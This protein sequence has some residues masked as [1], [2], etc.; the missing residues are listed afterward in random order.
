MGDIET[1]TT[2]TAAEEARGWKKTRK[3][4]FYSRNIGHAEIHA[5]EMDMQE[6]SFSAI[7]V[8]GSFD[9]LSEAIAAAEEASG[10]AALDEANTARRELDEAR[11]DTAAINRRL[12]FALV[13]RDEARAEV[14]TLRRR[15]G[16]LET[17][18]EWAAYDPE[19]FG[20]ELFSSRA[21]AIESVNEAIEICREDASEGWPEDVEQ[22]RLLRVAGAAARSIGYDSRVDYSF[23]ENGTETL[24]ALLAEAR[25]VAKGT[26][27]LAVGLKCADHGLTFSAARSAV[28]HVDALVDVVRG[29]GRWSGALAVY[30]EACPGWAQ[31]GTVEG[32]AANA[33][34]FRENAVA[35]AREQG[36]REVVE[37]LPTA[38]CV[39]A[40]G[41]I[42][43]QTSRRLVS[44]MTLPTADA[45][46]D[47][48]G[49]GS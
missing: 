19:G 39:A 25:D 8:P 41:F 34:R 17:G 6:G 47:E 29:K 10:V 20:F 44:E 30:A 18:S 13:S 11:A 24:N 31:D 46:A 3:T 36:R 45:P 12:E 15:V 28:E 26:E 16:E 48:D 22:I 23:R 21:K 38:A 35:E 5:H 42:D 14:E 2:L 32:M 27:A 9:T 43:E 33:K 40:C 1:K 4:E 49:G 37:A 7:G